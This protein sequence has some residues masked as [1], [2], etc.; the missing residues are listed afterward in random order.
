[1]QPTHPPTIVTTTTASAASCQ[2]ILA[3]ATFPHIESQIQQ[4]NS[5]SHSDTSPLQMPQMAIALMKHAPATP[6]CCTD[7]TN[8]L[9]HPQD[10]PNGLVQ[11]VTANEQ[12]LCLGTSQPV[13]FLHIN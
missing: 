6:N 7:L 3:S 13:T 2:S 4:Q 12:S 11:H 5:P 8:S 9:L 10:M 1:M